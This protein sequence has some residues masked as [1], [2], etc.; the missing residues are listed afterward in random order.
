MIQAKECR[1]C[2]VCCSVDM[3]AYVSPEDRK[4]WEREGRTDILSRLDDGSVTWAGDKLVSR[5]G[6]K[7]TGC[8]Y[9]NWDG[10]ACCCDIYPTRPQVCRDYVPGSSEL[11]PLYWEA[12]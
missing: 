2:G 7:I 11:C 1:R 12:D 4:R 8:F 6:A 10:A 3:M 5:S 9:L